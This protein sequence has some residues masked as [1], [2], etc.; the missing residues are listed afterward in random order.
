MKLP[1]PLP[2]PEEPR[3][4]TNQ[5]GLKD[6]YMGQIPDTIGRTTAAKTMFGSVQLPEKTQTSL[7]IKVENLYR[8][9]EGSL[10][11]QRT[12]EYGQAGSERPQELKER[13]CLEKIMNLQKKF[14]EVKNDV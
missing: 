4:S 12:P 11:G 14:N 13:D 10:P 5:N 9:R 2:E 6:Q 1:G 8:D 7:P 3:V